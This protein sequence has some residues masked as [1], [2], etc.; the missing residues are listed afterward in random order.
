[1]APTAEAQNAVIGVVIAGCAGTDALKEAL[2]SV[3]IAGY[4]VGTVAVVGLLALC[5]GFKRV[6]DQG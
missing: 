3:F 6:N 2:M 5:A 1:V 4:M